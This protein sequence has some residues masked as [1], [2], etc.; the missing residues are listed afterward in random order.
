MFLLFS[1]SLTLNAEHVTALGFSFK[2]IRNPLSSCDQRP[3][4]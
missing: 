3:W 4:W 2:G 1:E